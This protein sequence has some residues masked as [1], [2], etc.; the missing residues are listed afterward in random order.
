MIVCPV[1]KHSN[2]EFS[3]KCISC[4]SYI[5]DRVPNLD[6]FAMIWLMIE[7][8]S[9][10]YKKVIIAEH[11]NFVLF[12]SL[13]LGISAA[14]ALLW[15]K[16][17]GNSFDNLFPLLLF[18][19]A[20]GIAICIPLFYF[21]AVVFYAVLSLVKR[22]IEFKVIYGIIGWSLVPIMLSVIFI[23][24]LKLST[25]GLLLFS[26]NPSAYE[27]KPLVT[28]VLLGLDS[29]MILWSMIL[30]ATG[31]SIAYKLK[32]IISI[33]IVLLITGSTSFLSYLLYSS[34]NI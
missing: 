18:G 30:A 29:L 5:Q 1:C 11:K 33:V 20:I 13:F 17:S 14:F 19:T 10:A 9:K 7:S 32:F 4:G 31:I 24:P 12:F 27:V 2:D 6:L 3:I 23:L 16:K 25:L 21:L 15:I 34:F 22:E 8:P 28:I 26:T